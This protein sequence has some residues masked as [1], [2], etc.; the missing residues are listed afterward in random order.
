MGW[1]DYVTVSARVH[2]KHHVD[3]TSIPSPHVQAKFNFI[4]HQNLKEFPTFS[5]S[6]VLLPKYSWYWYDTPLE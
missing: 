4:S 5:V 3:F 6:F 2:F 1:L